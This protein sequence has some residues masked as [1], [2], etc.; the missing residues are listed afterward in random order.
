L[1]ITLS[2]FLLSLTHH[3]IERLLVLDHRGVNDHLIQLKVSATT[4]L[5]PHLK[6]TVGHQ[7]ILAWFPSLK[8]LTPYTLLIKISGW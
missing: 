1:T 7:I 5:H 2:L 4:I 8:Q 6:P 3:L